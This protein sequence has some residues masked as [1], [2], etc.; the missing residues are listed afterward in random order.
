LE[1]FTDFAQKL[2]DRLF[3][4]GEENER[5]QNCGHPR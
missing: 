1:I 2:I 3:A 5:T 4:T